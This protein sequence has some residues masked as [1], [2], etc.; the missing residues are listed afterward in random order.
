MTWPKGHHKNLLN[1]IV[2]DPDLK[3]SAVIVAKPGT[4]LA[5]GVA[6]NWTK[7]VEG[8]HRKA[9]LHRLAEQ[10]HSVCALVQRAILEYGGFR[11]G[12][13]E[14]P[15]DY[16]TKRFARPQD[17]VH[18]AAVSGAALGAMAR[19]GL[20]VAPADYKGQRPKAVCEKDAIEYFGW[21]R[22][23]RRFRIPTEVE[24]LTE[25]PENALEDVRDA[26]VIAKWALL[27]GRRRVGT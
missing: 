16:G 18:L 14:M 7:D 4:I 21:A 13:S 17:I 23:G 22:P 26:M 15:L 24:C 25:V 27:H 6:T 5:V 2:V 8:S 10:C 20:A 3:N 9:T 11:L 1:V 19:L 12:V